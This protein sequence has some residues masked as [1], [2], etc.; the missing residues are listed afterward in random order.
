MAITKQKKGVI[1]RDLE[2]NIKQANMV[3]FINFHGLNV[4]AASELRRML[5][6]IGAKITVA[7]K[8]LIKKAL[9]AAG[10]EGEMPSL[11]GEIAVAFSSE[12]P[13]VAAKAVQQFAKKNEAIK[14]IGGVFESGYIGKEKMIMLA[15]IPSREVLLGQFVNVISSPARGMV[16][17][18]NGVMKKFAVA[19]SEIAK[20]K[21]VA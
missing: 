7:K 1:L 20:Q 4:A 18:L 5:G 19:L 12:E 6:K 8:T 16:V 3:M 10:F 2:E 14:I 13:T 9:V 11:D 15:N 21:Q 17:T